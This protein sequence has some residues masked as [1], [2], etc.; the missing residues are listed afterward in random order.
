MRLRCVRETTPEG[1]GVATCALAADV[2]PP[3]APPA[4]YTQNTPCSCEHGVFANTDGV[5]FELTVR[6][7]A[8]TLSR[9]AP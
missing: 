8:H 4:P 2:T 3:P 5:R 7:H 6:F 9:R 1:A